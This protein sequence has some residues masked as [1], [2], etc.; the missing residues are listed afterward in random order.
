MAIVEAIKS[1]SMSTIVGDVDFA[2]GP[3]P[4]VT[5]TPLVAGQWQKQGDN[6]DLVVTTNSQAPQIPVGG[7]L[8]L[9]NV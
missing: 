5:K 9:L 4:N 1:T 8:K 2:N 7:E 6:F 3:V